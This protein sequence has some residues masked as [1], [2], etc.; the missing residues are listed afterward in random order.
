MGLELSAGITLPLFEDVKDAPLT[1]P[2]AGG[3]N[4]P[5]WLLGHLTHGEGFLFWD[6]MR[7]EANPV[8]EWGECFSGGTTPVAD[9]GK[10][11][12]YN[13]ILAKFH[14]LRGQTLALLDSLNEGD[15]DRASVNCPAERAGFFGTWRQCFLAASLHMMNHR[16][17]VAVC[18][19]A[20]GRKPL[21]A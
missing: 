3:G 17:Q 6:C 8:A 20:V 18:R 2:T 9:A 11:P 13:E 14:E 21:L 10:Y 19:R 15:L 1:Q 4:H 7:G 16:G 5:L 12:A